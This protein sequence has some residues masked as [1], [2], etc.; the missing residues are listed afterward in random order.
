M[1]VR[2][3]IGLALITYLAV[4]GIVRASS[5]AWWRSGAD[6]RDYRRRARRRI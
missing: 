1:I 3:L 2:E 6:R 4:E 5:L